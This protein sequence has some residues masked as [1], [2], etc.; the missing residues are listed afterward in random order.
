MHILFDHA[1]L[2]FVH[3][4]FEF[5]I[6]SPLKYYKYLSVLINNYRG[7]YLH[8]RSPQLVHLILI[9]EFNI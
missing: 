5:C 1:F 4:K 2:Y 9:N 7:V 6:L 3:V 8:A